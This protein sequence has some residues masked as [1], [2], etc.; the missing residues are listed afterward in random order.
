MQL[1]CA[2]NGRLLDRR[3]IDALAYEVAEAVEQRDV[4]V[5][6]VACIV[7]AAEVSYFGFRVGLVEARRRPLSPHLA[8]RREKDHDQRDKDS[9]RSRQEDGIAMVHA[10]KNSAPLRGFKINSP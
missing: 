6:A 9:V 4:S 10:S 1:P 5:I 7:V 2:I 8:A 3:P